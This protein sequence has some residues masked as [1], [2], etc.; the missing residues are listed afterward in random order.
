MFKYP[1]Q[2]QKEN[3]KNFVISGT[4]FHQNV[5][6]S[7]IE[8]KNSILSGK[9]KEFTFEALFRS[10]F[11]E[12]AFDFY[13]KKEFMLKVLIQIHLTLKKL[14]EKVIHIFLFNAV[15]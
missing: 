4:L 10:P 14:L 8:S 9:V 13:Y 1:Q 5:F 11:T 6:S 15:L 3:N 2:R 7:E 12:L